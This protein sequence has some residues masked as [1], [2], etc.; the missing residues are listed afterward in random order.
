MIQEKIDRIRTEIAQATHSFA[1][2]ALGKDKYSKQ[3][4]LV[5]RNAMNIGA[6]IVLRH[7][8]EETEGITALMKE[9]CLLKD[10]P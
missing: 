4:I 6:Q 8:A 7:I 2:K 1:T 10:L 5:I 9:D 3:D